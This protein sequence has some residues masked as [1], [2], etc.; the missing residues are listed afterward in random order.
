MIICLKDIKWARKRRKMSTPL[1]VLKL[2]T[3]AATRYDS[4]VEKEANIWHLL[5][6]EVL[7]ALL[8]YETLNPNPGVGAVTVVFLGWPVIPTACVLAGRFGS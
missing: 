4:M 5:V 6:P 1:I 2:A 7:P 8:R 3:L